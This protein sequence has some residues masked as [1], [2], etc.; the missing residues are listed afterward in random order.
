M[1]R[2]TKIIFIAS[3]LSFFWLYSF[4]STFWVDDDNCPGPG[5]GT[6][7]DPYCEIQDAIDASSDGYTIIIRRGTYVENLD[8][9]GKTITL[10]S[11]EPLNS[12]TVANTIIDGNGSDVIYIHYNSTVTINGLKIVG[13]ALGI[14][15]KWADITVENCIFANNSSTAIL[16]CC[17][18]PIDASNNLIVNNGGSGISCGAHDDIQCYA[19][20]NIIVDND[21]SGIVNDAVIFNIEDN[22][23]ANNNGDG[24]WLNDIYPSSASRNMIISNSGYG[25]RF[26]QDYT[27]ELDLENNIIAANENSGILYEYTTNIINNH[28]VSNQGSGIEEYEGDAILCPPPANPII[29]NNIIV[30]NSQYGI[31]ISSEGSAQISFN[32]VWDNS[33]GNY[34]NC[35]PGT[36][37]ISQDPLFIPEPIGTSTDVSYY[38]DTFIST[39]R[40]SSANWLEN[41]FAESTLN[42]NTSQSRQFYIKHNNA[43]SIMVYGDITGIASIGDPYEVINYRLSASSPLSSLSSCIDAGTNDGAS[44]ED[45]SGCTRPIDGDGDNISVTDMGSFEYDPNDFDNDGVGDD[46][47][48]CVNDINADQLDTDQD[49]IGD[50][51]DNCPI[52]VNDDQADNDIDGMGDVC[53]PDD[54]NDGYPDEVDCAPFDP[55]VHPGA[56]EICDGLDNDCDGSIDDNI[57][58]DDDGYLGCGGPDCN[59]ADPDINP[60]GTE[61]CDGID[62]N[63]DGSVDEVC[64]TDTDNPGKDGEDQPATGDDGD[65][66]IY[67]SID[68]NGTEYGMVWEDEGDG[69]WEIYFAR[70]NDLGEQIGNDTRIT[71]DDNSSRKPEIVWIGNRYGVTWCDD[72]DGNEEMYFVALS[73]TGS[74]LTADVRITNYAGE[75]S[76]PAMIWNGDVF[77][78][79]WQDN[80]DH[81]SGNGNYEIYFARLD[82]NGTKIGSDR[83][84]TYYASTKRN[85]SLGWNGMDFGIAWEDNRDGNFEIYY[86]RLD[87]F[88]NKIGNDV[89]ITFEEGDSVRPD[90]QWNG[91]IFGLVWQDSRATGALLQGGDGIYYNGIDSIGDKEGDDILLTGADSNSS[92]ANIVWSGG[93]SEWGV[94]FS[95]D[96]NGNLEIYFTNLYPDGTEKND[97]VRITD[98]HNTSDY[99]KIVRNGESYGTSWHDFRNDTSFEIYFATISDCQDNDNDTYTQCD[100]DCDDTNPDINPGAEEDICDEIDNNCDGTIEA[101]TT[102]PEISVSASPN[103]LWPPNHK[104]VKVNLAVQVQDSCDPDPV[105]ILYS[106]TS[107]EPDDAPGNGDGK[108]KNDIQGADIGT[109]DLEV[110]LRA[111]RQNEGPGR[112]YTVTYKATDQSGN[113]AYGFAEVIVPADQG[114]TDGQ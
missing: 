68:W 46:C 21:G 105:V 14:N 82:T 89:R 88:G 17:S 91:A 72:R 74:K 61:V 33:L 102:P 69:N 16:G 94:I 7:E 106:V 31:K 104:M 10:R 9:S 92:N 64:D 54:D 62:N 11:E 108:T 83:R 35:S 13:G 1:K 86:A 19:Q 112:I 12:E 50:I 113:E 40:D 41:E 114:G 37:D 93:H 32:D 73:S 51:C 75:S 47:D 58:M 71:N 110:K 100:G 5:S 36:G 77:G 20:S 28:F 48:N 2:F 56:T 49:G 24:L 60:E 42:P 6:Y 63:C 34:Y 15:C 78:I 52:D 57:D 59:D 99:P 45:Y 26:Y 95:D 84:I 22:I 98:A 18:C 96:R 111:E 90:I 85:P 103:L 55:N 8:I 107:S 79:T 39:L 101:D 97:E 76:F 80:R 87:A 23:I 43:T 30:K 4:P 66:S 53:D 3:I 65:D 67:S 109:F 25:V 81:L 27:D 70:L 38:P 44:T 29:K